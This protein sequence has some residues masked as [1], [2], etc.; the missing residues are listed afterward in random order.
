MVSFNLIPINNY[1][2]QIRLRISVT[3]ITCCILADQSKRK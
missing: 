1:F 3:F 2:E